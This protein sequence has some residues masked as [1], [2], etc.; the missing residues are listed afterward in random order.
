MQDV[1][2]RADD[3]PV[4]T[5]AVGATRPDATVATHGPTDRVFRWASVTKV[6]TA[7]TTLVAVQDG[8]LHLDEPAGPEGST[9]R[10]LLAMTS[11][12]TDSES[13]KIPAGIDPYAYL[14]L[15]PVDR[16]PGTRWHYDTQVYRLL[17][18]VLEAATGEP[19]QA[20][21]DSRL[22]RPLGL[23]SLA[24]GGATL[25][26]GMSTTCVTRNRLCRNR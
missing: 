11:G 2:A 8:H 17:F 15:L 6:L 7:W 10:H 21:T 1:L 12:L 25:T 19:L 26:I 24:W 4:D 18:P 3:W 5:V 13:Y 22:S 20:Y 14:S 16:T 9:V 23:T